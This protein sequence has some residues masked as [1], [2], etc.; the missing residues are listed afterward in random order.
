MTYDFM[1]E[2]SLLM[3]AI[4]LTLRGDSVKSHVS[5]NIMANN[6]CGRIAQLVRARP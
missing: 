4:D 5:A 2:D 3:P 6:A 1:P